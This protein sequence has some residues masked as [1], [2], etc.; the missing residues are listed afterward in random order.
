MILK[1]NKIKIV[2]IIIITFGIEHGKSV[3]FFGV[4]L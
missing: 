2:M 1:S 4:D 3:Q